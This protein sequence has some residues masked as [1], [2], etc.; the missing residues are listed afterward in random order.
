MMGKIYITVAGRVCEPCLGFFPQD[1]VKTSRHACIWH[2]SSSSSAVLQPLKGLDLCCSL[3]PSLSIL[4]HHS[5]SSLSYFLQIFLHIVHPS[6]SG[7][8]LPPASDCK[9]RNEGEESTLSFKPPSVLAV[10]N[11]VCP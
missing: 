7:P 3:P 2:T 11:S 1:G 8:S 10:K 6:Q 5:P 9:M 4:C